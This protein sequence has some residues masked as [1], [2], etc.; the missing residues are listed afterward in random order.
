MAKFVV[1]FRGGSAEWDGN[2]DEDAMSA[3]INWFGQIGP[4]ILEM[5]NPFGASTVIEPDGTRHE[6]GA[7]L[8]GY[9][10]LEAPSLDDAAALVAH[11]PQFAAGG[12]I[13]LYEAMPM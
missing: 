9:T 12:S 1:V 5:G 11:C 7:G 8:Q 4:S 6:R 13:E 10:V 2:P 3:W